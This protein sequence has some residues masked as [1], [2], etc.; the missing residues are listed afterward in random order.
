MAREIFDEAGVR[1][2]LQDTETIAVLGAHVE[3]H[4]AACYV[5]DYLHRVG[6]YRVLP[7]NPR[8][9]GRTLFGSPTV[10]RL[11]ELLE[12][13]DLLDVFRRREHL[14]AH[15]AEV[16]AL[17]PRVVW[18]QLGIRDDGFAAACVEQGIDVVQDRC[19]LADHR[20]LGIAPRRR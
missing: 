19:T 8:F 12:P 18:L 20:A 1:R 2:V 6:G 14:A 13:V 10:A 17:R 16:L 4:K 3:G 11:D 15:L 9:A 5:P 7:V